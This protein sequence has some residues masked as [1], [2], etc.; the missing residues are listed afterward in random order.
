MPLNMPTVQ[1]G[2]PTAEAGVVPA[3]IPSGRALRGRVALASAY[4]ASGEAAGCKG[5]PSPR[6]AHLSVATQVVPCGARVQICTTTGRCVVAVRRDTGPFTGGRQFDLNLGVV[7]AL[8]VP[9]VYAWGVRKV[10][11]QPMASNP[12]TIASSVAPSPR[13]G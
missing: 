12:R 9:S 4:N 3:P 10:L 7:H 11:W 6:S 1:P 2:A 5:S 13:R 8:G